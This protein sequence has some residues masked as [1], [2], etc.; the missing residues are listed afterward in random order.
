MDKYCSNRRIMIIGAGKAGEMILSEYISEKKEDLIICF[1]DDDNKKWGT[2]VLNLKSVFGPIEKATEIIK[3]FE[4]NEIII[5]IPSASQLKIQSIIKNLEQENFK[6]KIF[7]L[8]SITKLI[9]QH[10]IKPFIRKINIEDLLDKSEFTINL[11][12]LVPFYKGKTVFV[13]GAGG[14]IGSFLC[15]ELLTLEVDKLIMIG[16]GEYSIFSLQ[17]KLSLFNEKKE[18][19]IYHI[20]DIRDKNRINYLINLYKPDIIIHTAAHKHVHFMENDPYESFTNN[21]IGT[22]NLLEVAVDSKVTYF[23]NIS[24]DKAVESE[25]IYGI[26]KYLTEL[27]TIRFNGKNNLK[28]FSVRFGN[29]IGSKGSVIPL[30]QEQIEN[31][32]PVTIT[33]PEMTR[34]FMSIPEASNLILSS[35]MLSKGGETFILDMGYPYKILEIAKTLIKMYGYNPDKDIDIVFTGLRKGEKIHESLSYQSEKL[36]KTENK[37]MKKK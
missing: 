10:P 1:C 7:I 27:L 35:L 15:E 13:T 17:N 24:T 20:A 6:G 32:G 23:I 8:P 11:D 12:T 19:Q 26:T 22:L 36:I 2:K 30:F 31:G 34:Y 4:I 18:K 25:S 33:H 3:K 37:K 29:V 21:V 28:A 9:E 5:A 14:S 16:R